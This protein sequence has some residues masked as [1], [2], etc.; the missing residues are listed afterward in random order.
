MALSEL[1]WAGLAR[2]WPMP[3][4]VAR[5][6]GELIYLNPA[7]KARA[8]QGARLV[9][10]L[11]APESSA[12]A[13]LVIRAESPPADP[14]KVSVT[15]PDSSPAIMTLTAVPDTDQVLGELRLSADPAV[16]EAEKLEGVIQMARALGHELNQPL[17]I[18][19]G[20]AE[21]LLMRLKNDEAMAKRLRIIIEEVERMEGIT[22]KLSRIVRYRTQTYADGTSIVDL[23]KATD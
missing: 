8:P 9:S 7:L 23:D 3:F 19:I 17:T 12:G 21:I 13:R 20:Q 11:L 4:F 6:N 14:I 10:D 22:R 2:I 15:L 18:I 5:R 16:S 1:D